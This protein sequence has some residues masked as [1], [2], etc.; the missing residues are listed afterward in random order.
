M[1][2]ASRKRLRS[3]RADH[4]DPSARVV[5][6]ARTGHVCQENAGRHGAIGGVVRVGV[7]RVPCLTGGRE[8]W[9]CALNETLCLRAGHEAGL[10][11]AEVSLVEV[12][13]VEAIISHRYDRFQRPEGG[14]WMR[15]HQED[16]CQA[17]AVH[18][19]QKYQNQ[20]GPGVAEVADLLTRLPLDDRIRS[21][22]RF[23]K[24]LAFNVLIGGTDAHAK[25]YS[26]VLIGPRPDRPARRRRLRG[27]V[28]AVTPQGSTRGGPSLRA[29]LRR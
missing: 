20:G 12:A 16:L 23:F 19:S 18:P 17:L 25:N 24:A 7:G 10:A 1:R 4:V 11:A 29:V 5:R 3:G 14:R 8:S 6:I 26:L 13:D 27:G 28:P 15:L 21:A 22:E 2:G 9:R